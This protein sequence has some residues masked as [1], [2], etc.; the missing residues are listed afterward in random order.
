MA[1]LITN[2]TDAPQPTATHTNMCA[3]STANSCVNS[4]INVVEL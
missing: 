4:K 3:Q 1:S 2:D